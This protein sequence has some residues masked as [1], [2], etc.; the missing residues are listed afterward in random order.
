[1]GETPETETTEASPAPETEPGPQNGSTGETVSLPRAAFNERISRAAT[2]AVKKVLSDL[3]FED[4][5]SLKAFVTTSREREKSGQSEL[6][7]LTSQ[8]NEQK[9]QLE[10]LVQAKAQAEKTAA[11]AEQKQRDAAR[12][13][14]IREQ[15]K[16]AHDPGDIIRWAREANL[17]GDTLNKDG[18]VNPEAIQK[19]VD[20]ARQE[21]PHWFK[22]GPGSPS[23]AGGVPTS[24]NKEREQAVRQATRQRAR[25]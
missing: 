15:A 24:P 3:G 12:D 23:N 21:K 11:E 17:L 2:T 4:A 6:Q 9:T 16:G 20:K 5:D 8:L 19:V 22:T 25:L 18:S 14:V 10:T 13:A 7:K 1:M